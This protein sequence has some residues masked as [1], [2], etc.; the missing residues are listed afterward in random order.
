[1]R[2]AQRLDAAG[3]LDSRS[4]LAHGVHLDPA[5]ID[6]VRAAGATV[7]HNPASNMNNGVGRAPLA[8]LGE[9]VALGTD[10]IGADMFG[11]AHLAYV[12]HRED[13]LAIGPDWA[14]GRLAQGSRVAGEAFG[15]PLLGRIEAGAPADLAVLDYRP[16][17]RLDAGDLAG[18]WV[19]GLSAAAV[20][21]VIVA[22]EVVVRDRRLTRVDETESPPWAAKPPGGCGHVSTPS[23]PI[24]SRRTRSDR[25][26]PDRR[27]R[28]PPLPQPRPAR[29][30]A[31]GP[32][33]PGARPVCRGRCGRPGDQDGLGPRR[34]ATDPEHRRDP[35]RARQHGALVGAAARAVDRAG[36]RD[37]RRDR[38]AGHRQPWLQRR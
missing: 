25:G 3:A 30:R 28:G 4:L 9:R 34:G 8:A 15:E 13:D 6:L 23:T 35:P 20:R 29:R 14:L 27:V 26:R 24:P 32:R 11:E 7:V 2:V 1:M 37:G 36:V 17:T 16:P 10:G 12:R 22:G 21:D 38:A 31:A 19:F 18:H 5:E 33:R